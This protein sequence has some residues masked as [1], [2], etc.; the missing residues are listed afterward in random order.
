[1]S[2]QA[3]IELRDDQVRDPQ[4]GS[5][6]VGVTRCKEPR[7][8]RGQRVYVDATGQM[9]TIADPVASQVAIR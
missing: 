1:M 5:F 7:R 3:I 2:T 9:F 4:R 8:H 6:R